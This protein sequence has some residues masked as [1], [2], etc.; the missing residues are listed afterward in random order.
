ME[1]F[2]SRLN[3]SNASASI[4]WENRLDG[5][6]TA[7]RSPIIATNIQW[8]KNKKPYQMKFYFI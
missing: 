3:G 1:A 6:L 8:G 5:G 4:L 7:R 2:I